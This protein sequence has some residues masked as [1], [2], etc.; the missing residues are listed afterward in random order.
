MTYDLDTLGTLK[1][2]IKCWYHD[3]RMKIWENG[4]AD[5]WRANEQYSHYVL[6]ERVPLHCEGAL[7]TNVELEK[8]VIERR[9]A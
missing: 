1:R 9:S 7:A 3:G 5:T 4:W 2:S 8:A 6:V